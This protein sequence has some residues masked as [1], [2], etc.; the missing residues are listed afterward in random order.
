VDVYGSPS[1]ITAFDY[2]NSEPLV[3]VSPT[4]FPISEVDTYFDGSGKYTITG[5]GNMGEETYMDR[6][7]DMLD[8][9]NMASNSATKTATQQSIKAY[10]DTKQ[11]SDADLT[12]IAALTPSND[13]VMQRKAGA[14]TNRT[15]AQLLVD[16]AAAGTTFQPLDSDLTSW[17][18]ITRAAGFDTFTATPSGANLA[19]LLTSALP[20]SKGG[21]GLTALAANVVSILSAADYSAIRTL[22]GLVI[23]TNVQA[24]DADLST[25]AGLTPTTDNFMQAK[26]SAWASRTPAQV[27]TDLK[28]DTKSAWVVPQS[29]AGAE[30]FYGDFLVRSMGTTGEVGFTWFVPSDFASF[31]SVLIYAIPDATES[32][33]YDIDVDIA[34]S[35]EAYTTHTAQ[36]L[37]ATKSV[38]LNQVYTID[39]TSLL[40]L[41]AAGD[42]IGIRLGSDTDFMYIVGMKVL[43]NV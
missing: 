17:A 34:A 4:G 16:L 11:T 35:G 29:P 36:S 12:A 27:R 26:S 19:S 14:W 37:N 9:D 3:L 7:V 33:Q 32:I 24:Y 8:E 15:I 28:V 2:N 25:I 18:A 30:S 40:S 43:Y 1:G 42:I 31:N 13:D 5:K 20:A 10:A 6:Y 22:L 23:G 39:I 38:T 21:T 41:A